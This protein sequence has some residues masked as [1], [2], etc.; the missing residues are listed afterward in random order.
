MVLLSTDRH[1]HGTARKLPSR[2]GCFRPGGILVPPRPI[3][4]Y[5]TN[6]QQAKQIRSPYVVQ[7]HASNKHAALLRTHACIHART[8]HDKFH[9][10]PYLANSRAVD[11]PQAS[12]R[13]ATSCGVR[14]LGRGDRL[15]A[16]KGQADARASQAQNARIAYRLLYSAITRT[17]ARGWR[18][19]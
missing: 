9:T 11:E 17:R 19:D 5:K 18:P 16:H 3:D 15:L 6:Q 14:L 8:A 13:R 12:R 10:D 1:A 2:E 7:C 4:K